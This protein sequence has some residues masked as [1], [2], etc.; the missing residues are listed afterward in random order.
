MSKKKIAI[1]AVAVV[2]VIAAV[3]AA[4]VLLKPEAN[5]EGTLE[6]I[7]AKVYAGFG[8]DELPML[9]DMP[10]DVTD[11]DAVEYYLGT[12]ELSIKEALVREPMMGS[13]PHSVVLVRLNDAKDAK[14]AV[15]KIKEKANPRK[16]ICVQAKNVV[17]DSIGDLV[18]LIMVDSEGQTTPEIAPKLTA[19]FGG[20]K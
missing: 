2:V 19:N 1:I 15:A 12:S 10:V 9:G 3:V 5:V 13:I 7:M 4:V 8:E 17:V 16:W 11:K 6:E 20:L 18:I 14:A